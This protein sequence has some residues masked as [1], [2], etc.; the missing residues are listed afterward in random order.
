MK[1]CRK[2]GKRNGFS[3]IELLV[4]IAIISILGAV[5]VPKIIQH[6]GTTKKTRAEMDM[7]TL[8]TEAKTHYLTRQ[9]HITSIQDL[10]PYLE[11]G[12]PNDP[13]GGQYSIEKRSDG[14][15]KIVCVNYDMKYGDGKREVDKIDVELGRR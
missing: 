15:V 2:S 10:A 5:A 11:D 1:K 7:K 12:V 3:L 13:W 6:I 4:V 14:S 9:T 8:S